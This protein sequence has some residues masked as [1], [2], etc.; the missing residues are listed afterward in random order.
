MARRKRKPKP[1]TIGSEIA[2]MKSMKG[3]LAWLHGY[4]DGGASCHG[5]SPEECA[6]LRDAVALWIG[7]NN[8][9]PS[10]H[11]PDPGSKP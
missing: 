6:E 5:I 10:S 3:V 7:A 11:N 9:I 1:I 8:W 2:S 4:F